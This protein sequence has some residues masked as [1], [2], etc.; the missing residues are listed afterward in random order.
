MKPRSSP[1]LRQPGEHG[2]VLK[3]LYG[4][5]VFLSSFMVLWILILPSSWLMGRSEVHAS[6]IAEVIERHY[7][8]GGGIPAK[9]LTKYAGHSLVQLTHILPG[10][11]WAGAIPFQLNPS[12]RRKHRHAHRVLGHIF[13]SASLA[14]AVG[15]LLILQRNLA[16]WNDYPKSTPRISSHE[17]NYFLAVGT[18][19]AAWFAYTALQAFAKIRTGDVPSH[20]AFIIRHVASGVWVALQRIIV[21]SLQGWGVTGPLQ[22][23][24]WFGRAS[25][26]SIFLTIP[27]GEYAIRLLKREAEANTYKAN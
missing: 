2:T 11:L 14:M 10:A 21:L 20:R 23:R 19:G 17:E 4:L 18:C 22:M 15:I 27:A 24:Y 12:V 3:L 25:E 26:I 9:T 13:L 6:L 16:Y 1:P 7:D 8:E 5:T